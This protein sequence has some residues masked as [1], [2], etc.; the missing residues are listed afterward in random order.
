M[1]NEE[2]N[3]VRD[4]QSRARDLKRHVDELRMSVE[5][6]VSLL[7]GMPH[8]KQLKSR[9]ESLTL[10]IVEEE[11]EL[12]ALREEILIAKSQLTE[13]ILNA[14]DKPTVQ[15]LLILR[16]VEC[17]SFKETARRMK[18]GLRHIFKLHEKFLKWHI[19]AQ[20]EV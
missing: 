20:I 19:A 7:D 13:L 14:T 11:R 1:T 8:A 16:Y 5:N 12:E 15:T 17:L 4:L 3:S 10:K 6:L 2:L 18:Y 9:V